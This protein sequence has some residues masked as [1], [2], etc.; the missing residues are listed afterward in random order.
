MDDRTELRLAA[1]N[2]ALEAHKELSLEEE[3]I[4]DTARDFLVFLSGDCFAKAHEPITATVGQQ[5]GGM[6]ANDGVIDLAMDA[7]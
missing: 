7:A 1:L 2:L 5:I 3:T 4:T 6:P